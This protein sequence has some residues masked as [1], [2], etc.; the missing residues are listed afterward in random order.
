M[1]YKTNFN[2]NTYLFDGDNFELHIGKIDSYILNEDGIDYF[3]P[4]PGILEKLGIL[5]TTDCNGKCIYCYQRDNFFNDNN[6]FMNKNVAD[7]IINKL[8]GMYKR[9]KT[10]SFF[11]G[12]PLLNFN[13]MKYITEELDN[14]FI[15][16]RFIITSN[17]VL[18]SD[19]I[20]DFLIKY[21]FKIIISIDGPEYI[22]DKLRGNIRYKDIVNTIQKISEVNL[23]DNLELNCT[24]TNIHKE[25]IEYD[26]LISF[27]DSFNIPYHISDVITEDRRLKIYKQDYDRYIKKCIE[28]TYERIINNSLNREMIS[29][30]RDLIES[31]VYG[32]A[33]NKFCNEFVEGNS[34][35]Y[36]TKGNRHHCIS[37]IKED[38][39]FEKINKINTKDRYPCNECRANNICS[40]CIVRFFYGKSKQISRLNDCKKKIY[41]EYSVNYL[42]KIYDRSIDEFEK[43]FNNYINF[44]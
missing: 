14:D 24:Y 4:E 11:G 1:I 38:I 30:V 25:N 5:L 19:E 6:S 7:K 39:D 27:F 44:W 17:G 29:Y 10:A 43:L 12:E 13:I 41:Y 8:S 15:V 3:K 21:N 16:D 31:M 36:D 20:I 34:E 42:I 9:I 33:T 23:Y 35:T 28:N 22:N 18:F 32:Y 26:K 37:L 2:G 40:D